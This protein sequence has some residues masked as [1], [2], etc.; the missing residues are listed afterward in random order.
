MA[1]EVPL[2]Q[3]CRVYGF[4]PRRYRQMEK[5]DIV[6][7]VKAGHID[8]L[9]ATKAVVEY[10]RNLASGSGSLTLTDERTRLTRINADR[11]E[12]Q[13]QKERGVLIRTEVAQRLW[14]GIIMTMKT[15][16]LAMP[17]KL[18]PAVIGQ[19]RLPEIEDLISK[20]ING[21]LIEFSEPDLRA[22]AIGV[23]LLA[24]RKRR[25]RRAKTVPAKEKTKR[26]PVGEGGQ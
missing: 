4:T 17:R 19:E 16:L 11:K 5:E 24:G 9:A 12:L 20:E 1:N 23:G 26:K 8:F 3:A 2:E 21:I 14:S 18:A 25:K 6:P 15:R 13:L 22:I 7:A 10:Y